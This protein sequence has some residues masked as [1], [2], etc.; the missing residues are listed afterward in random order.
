[1]EDLINSKSSLSWRE[2]LDAL[3]IGCSINVKKRFVT[4][5]RSIVSKHFHRKEESKKCFTVK[6]DPESLSGDYRAWRKNDKTN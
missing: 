2:R 5:V 6:K 1:M 4:S 3:N